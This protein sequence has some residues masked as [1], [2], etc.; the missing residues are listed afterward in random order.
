MFRFRR[1]EHEN[2]LERRRETELTFTASILIA[3]AILVLAWLVA[4]GRITPEAFGNAI[5]LLK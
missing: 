1:T 3:I 4:S 5:D 2:N